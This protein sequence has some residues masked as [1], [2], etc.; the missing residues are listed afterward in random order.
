M[1]FISEYPTQDTS[2][3][4][5]STTQGASYLPHFTTNPASSLTGT[6]TNNQWLSATDA[7]TNQRFHIDLGSGK[8]ITRIYYENAHESGNNTNAGTQ[9]FT[10][11][12]TTSASSFAE[13]TY[14]IDTGW[15]Q[16]TPSQ[17]TFDQHTGSN[18]VDPKYITVTNST[19]YRYYAFKFADNYGNGNF[20]GV[21]RIE[22][23]SGTATTFIPK[24]NFL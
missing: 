18:I 13:L 7:I 1:A 11:W 4:I 14:A 12:G 5:A 3:V 16:I 10:F 2:H 9:N 22:L 23:Q 21:R 8:I 17:S 24:V 6:W 15:T 19:A 20:M